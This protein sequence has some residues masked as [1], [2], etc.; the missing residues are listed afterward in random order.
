MRPS[1]RRVVGRFSIGRSRRSLIMS[2]RGLLEVRGPVIYTRAG[3]P[4]RVPSE[5]LPCDRGARGAA[6]PGSPPQ[7]GSDGSD[8][9]DG[10]DGPDG[11]DDPDGVD[12]PDRVG[13]PRGAS[14]VGGTDRTDGSAVSVNREWFDRRKIWRGKFVP[15][16]AADV[17]V[18]PP[19]RSPRCRG[20]AASRSF[21]HRTISEEGFRRPQA[22][23]L[24]VSRAFGGS[25]S[26]LAHPSHAPVGRGA[27]RRLL[28]PG[29]GRP[30]RP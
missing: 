6:T 4:S 17:R 18:V 29:A 22:D 1:K 12:G 11:S 23:R 15:A 30:E 25:I 10:P 8:G 28:G 27:S 26:H 21:D 7:A 19:L 5:R 16:E 2:S 14:D 9:P 3:V 13:G 24:R 20:R